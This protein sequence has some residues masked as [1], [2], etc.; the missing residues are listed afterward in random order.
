MGEIIIKN[1]GFRE[2]LLNR[3]YNSAGTYSQFRDD[4]YFTINDNPF[5]DY[6]YQVTC[7]TWQNDKIKILTLPNKGRLYYLTNPN[8]GTPVYANVTIGQMILVRDMTDNKVLKFNAEGDSNNQFTGNYLTEF[9]I[10]R[11]CGVNSNNI[12]ASVK[13]NMVDAQVNIPEKNELYITQNC[14]IQSGSSPTNYDTFCTGSRDFTFAEILNTNVGYVRMTVNGGT[15]ELG[16]SK[17]GG[18]SLVL[19]EVMAISTNLTASLAS[20][21]INSPAAYPYGYP[22]QPV[23]ASYVF[24]YSLNGVDNWIYFYLNLRNA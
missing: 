14:E 20:P 13:L 11:F 18:S 4:V 10:E 3:N 5:S 8:S 7:G 9:K 15:A 2:I 12:I 21:G 6:L 24:Q 23:P 17:F 1:K 19:L 16:I 22:S